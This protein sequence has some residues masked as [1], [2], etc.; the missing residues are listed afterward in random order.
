MK[1]ALRS[2]LVVTALMAS[3]AASA[4]DELMNM[5]IDAALKSSAATSRIDPNIKLSFGF[6]KLDGAQ[7]PVFFKTVKRVRRPVNKANGEPKPTDAQLCESVFVEAVQE[8]QQRASTAGNNGVMEI[9]SNWKDDETSS[10]TTYVCAKGMAY[11]GVALKGTLVK[12]GS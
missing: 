9:R 12:V 8:L 11:I 6:N 4:A 10:E 5:P 2:A 3:G 7:S 1:T